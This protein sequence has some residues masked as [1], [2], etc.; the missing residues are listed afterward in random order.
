ME[1]SEHSEETQELQLCLP[2]TDVQGAEQRKVAG[3]FSTL[4]AEVLFALLCF[5]GARGV[6]TGTDP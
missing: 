3:G 4:T 6:R 1:K 2:L 5:D